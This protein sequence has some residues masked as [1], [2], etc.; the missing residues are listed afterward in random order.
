MLTAP[1]PKV[2]ATPGWWP[3]HAM[4]QWLQRISYASSVAWCS[5][6]AA[7]AHLA[8][9][10]VLVRVLGLAQDEACIAIQQLL[11]HPHRSQ[12]LCLQ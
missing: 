10:A 12:K 8:S 6:Q 11:Q 1:P 7:D 5:R 9:H 4:Q 3:C 2:S